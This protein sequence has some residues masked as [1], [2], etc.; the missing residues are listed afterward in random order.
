MT[1]PSEEAID[2]IFGTIVRGHFCAERGFT[3]EVSNMA[4]QLVPLTR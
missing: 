1:I 4:T 3:E 2:R